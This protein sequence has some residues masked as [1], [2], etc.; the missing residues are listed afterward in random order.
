LFTKSDNNI[1]RDITNN[2]N[3]NDDKENEIVLKDKIDSKSESFKDNESMNAEINT[4]SED[5][6]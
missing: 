3:S 4:S 5:E 6:N 2:E 1:H